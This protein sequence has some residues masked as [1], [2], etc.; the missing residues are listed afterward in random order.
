MGRHTPKTTFEHFK[1]FSDNPLIISTER[2][3]PRENNIIVSAN[4]IFNDGNF[5]NRGFAELLKGTDCIREVT[6]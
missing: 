1:Q 6:Y 4:E 5:F 2:T 3:M